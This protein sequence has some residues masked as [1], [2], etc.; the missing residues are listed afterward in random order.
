MRSETTKQKG[1]FWETVRTLIYTVLIA[2][3]IRTFGFEPFNIPSGSMIP[4]LLVGDYLFV[5]KFSYGYSRFSVP[6]GLGPFEGRV[7]YDPPERGDVAVFKLP[8]DNSTDYIKRIVGMP[9]DQIQV[10]N[11]VLY[12]N[13]EAVPRERVGQYVPRDGGAG[14]PATEFIETLPNG[15]SYSILEH[16]VNGALDNTPV[17]SVPEGHFFAMGDNRDQ[18]ADS[19]VDRVG[20]IPMDNL[21]GR[22]EIMFFSV[23]GESSFFAVWNWPFAIRFDRIF[24]S[25]E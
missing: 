23:T 11:S 20:F 13:G 2:F 16:Q 15:R 8:R 5:S 12:I 24:Q 9:G 10:R 1:G 14:T 21:V 3:V 22:A 18:S 19:R 17:Y 7:F 4:T 6:F 25:I